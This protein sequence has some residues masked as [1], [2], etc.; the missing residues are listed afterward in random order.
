MPVS[1]SCEAFGQTYIEAMAAGIPC[2]FTRSGIANEILKDMENACVVG[3]RDSNSIKTSY[4]KIHTNIKLASKISANA[5]DTAEEFGVEKKFKAI[6]D[7]FS[8]LM[9]S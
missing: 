5:I 6:R 3:Y 2:V 7:V 8:K 1:P 4:L 9:V